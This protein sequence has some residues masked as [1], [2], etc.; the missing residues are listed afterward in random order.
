MPD[1]NKQKISQYQLSLWISTVPPLY[2]GL[3]TVKGVD[4]DD[5]LTHWVVTRVTAQM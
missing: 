5:L 3:S 4:P 1:T 2:Q